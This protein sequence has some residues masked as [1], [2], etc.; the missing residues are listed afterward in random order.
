MPKNSILKSIEDYNENIQ[1]DILGKLE[2][3]QMLNDSEISAYTLTDE[4]A[5]V[6]EV[7]TKV[8]NGETVQGFTVQ[9]FLAS[10]QAK[11]LIP[12]VLIGT[13]RKAADPVYLASK[14][15]KSIRIKKGGSAIQFPEFGVM[16]AYDVGEGMEIPQET[17][18]WQL[19]SNNLIKV[20]KSG[21]R[22]QYSKELFDDTEFDIVGMLTS[23]AGRALARHAEQKAFVEFKG[24][25]WT[26]F[27]NALRRVDPVMF[28]DA[29]TTGLD[30]KG[31]FNDTLSIDDYLDLIIAVYNNGYTPDRKSV[32]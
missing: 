3:N 21:V 2:K 6:L 14:F 8:V 5:Q 32:V 22:V 11:V 30:F 25:G 17:I 19:N 28:A 31:D 15:F 18:D 23:E 27:D 12:R 26:V 29:G 10:P 9:D 1:K 7:L 20:G 13:A 24:H 16:R 4:D